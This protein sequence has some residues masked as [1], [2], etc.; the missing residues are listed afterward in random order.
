MLIYVLMEI[1]GAAT[2]PIFLVRSEPLYFGWAAAI[3]VCGLL[4]QINK[5]LEK[6]AK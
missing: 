6:G 3:T 5:Q 4:G 1:V 2:M